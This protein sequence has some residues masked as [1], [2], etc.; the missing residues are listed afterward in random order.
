MLFKRKLPLLLLLMGISINISMATN[1]SLP[2]DFAVE[3]QKDNIDSTLPSI[4]PPPVIIAPVIPETKKNSSAFQLTLQSHSEG[5]RIG[6]AISFSVK[7]EQG[8]YLT[9]LNVGTT[10]KTTVLFPNSF[11]RKNHIVANKLFLLPSE[12]LMPV[13]ALHIGKA[14]NSITD[15]ETII[16]ICRLK[17]KPLFKQAYQ[18]DDY[19]FRVFSPLENWQ[20]QISP[21]SPI[22]KNQE[23]RSKISFTAKPA[24]N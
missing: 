20:E 19:N 2:P 21:I 12:E 7:S 1:Y 10:G 14:D 9:V 18:F 3:V 5:Y 4:M 8:C 22:D 23:T 15:D 6:D 13:E 16:A 11:R 17:N 24:I